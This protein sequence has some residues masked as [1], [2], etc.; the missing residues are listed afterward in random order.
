[1]IRKLAPFAAA[2][3]MLLFFVGPG[4]AYLP[5]ALQLRSSAPLVSSDQQAA[6]HD[7]GAT[8]TSSLGLAPA[9]VVNP[10]ATAARIALVTAPA[11]KTERGYTLTATVRAPSGDALADANVRFFEL[12][13]LF[14]T[15]E[16]Y[17]G[18]A[19]TDGRGN[20]AITYLPAQI[21]THRLVVRTSTNGKISPGE[22]RTTF[23]ASISAPEAKVER[24]PLAAF[25]DRVPYAAGLIV[26][27]VWGLIAFALL[28]TARGVFGGARPTTRKE[29]PA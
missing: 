8:T 4:R 26:L 18:S 28:A 25:S 6:E 24:P 19:V 15:R 22:A 11:E 27:A 3:V 23:E 21:G 20:A 13:D 14:G 7:H 9:P 29:E 2:A 12:V 1:M 17:V 10:P 16:M 5:S